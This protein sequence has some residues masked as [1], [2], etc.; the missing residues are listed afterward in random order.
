MSRTKHNRIFK[1]RRQTFR[2]KPFRR[3]FKKIRLGKGKRLW[4]EPTKIYLTAIKTKFREI[5]ATSRQ[6]D[7]TKLSELNRI[8]TF[9]APLS[10]K[11]ITADQ[12]RNVR[13]HQKEHKI[14]DSEIKIDEETLIGLK[15]KTDSTDFNL[16]EKSVRPDSPEVLSDDELSPHM[17][18]LSL[19][20]GKRKSKRRITKRR[21]TKR[22]KSKRR[23]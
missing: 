17:R 2:K 18:R 10:A 5:K 14:Y 15:G 23:H 21:G 22:R 9:L 1:K 13:K 19:G 20:Q 12:L 3:T 4:E 16:F 8:T 6:E 7:R 11:N